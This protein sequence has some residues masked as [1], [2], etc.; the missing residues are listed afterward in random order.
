MGSLVVDRNKPWGTN[1]VNGVE[2]MGL[3]I[4]D[5]EPGPRPANL[6]W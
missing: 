4:S 5:F 6:I 1:F 2:I 3:E